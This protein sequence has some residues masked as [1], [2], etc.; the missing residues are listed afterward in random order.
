MPPNINEAKEIVEEAALAFRERVRAQPK[1]VG[2][3][4]GARVRIKWEEHGTTTTYSLDPPLPD[5]WSV[6]HSLAENLANWWKTAG[7]EAEELTN[8]TAVVDKN[9]VTLHF[10]VT[11]TGK[12]TRPGTFKFV[13]G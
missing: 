5:G 10:R 8:A 12:S 6:Q 4:S 2:L 13:L 1:E 3:N 11:L 7:A 9:A